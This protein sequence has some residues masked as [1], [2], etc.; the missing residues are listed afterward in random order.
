MV[1]SSCAVLGLDFDGRYL[2]LNEAELL[3]EVEDITAAPLPLTLGGKDVFY[4]KKNADG[5]STIYY[6]IDGKVAALQS[7]ESNINNEQDATE[8][9]ISNYVEL[10]NRRGSFDGEIKTLRSRDLEL[11][12]STA[13]KWIDSGKTSS[14]C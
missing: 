11:F 6:L 9:R 5:S 7:I 1:V 10:L 3:V 14:M 13:L 2:G 4:F 8:R 12:E